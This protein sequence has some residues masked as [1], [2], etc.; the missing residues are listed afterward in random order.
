MDK[1]RRS[2][3]TWLGSLL[4]L[5]AVGEIAQAEVPAVPKLEGFISVYINVGQLPPFKA[6]LL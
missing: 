6:R 1:N 5:G 2:F 4:G 3:M